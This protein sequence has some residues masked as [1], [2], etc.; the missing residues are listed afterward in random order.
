[1][2][3]CEEVDQYMRP[4]IFA[5]YLPQ[6]HETEENNAWWGK[7]Y[8]DWTAVKRSSPLFKGHYQPR[9]PLNRNYYDLTNVETIR[10][11]AAMAKKYG[12]DGLCIYHYWSKGKLIMERPA[13]ILLQASDI[14]ISFFLSWAN[15]DFKRTWFDG[16][17]ACL[18]KQEYGD[19]L[20]AR[21]HYEY[22]SNFFRDD[23]YKK[24]NN[25]PVLMIHN[26]YDI[27]D[28]DQKMSFWTKLAQAE[29]YAGLYIIATKTFTMM[30]SKE[31]QKFKYVDAV[32]IFEPMNV[33]TNGANEELYYIYI[34]RAR[35]WLL[36]QL[37]RYLKIQKPEIF[38]YRAANERMLKRNK[39]G[40]QYYCIFP[41][42]DN[43]PRYGGKGIVFRGS[44]P[45]LFEYYAKRF[46]RR[47]A[48]EGCEFLLVNAWNEWGESAYLEPDEKYGY[49][50]L[51][52]LKRAVDSIR[53]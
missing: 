23:R 34:R 4:E 53:Q 32:F 24:I 45:E 43:T 38:D 29:G 33:R 8:T 1:M 44:T 46:Y 36:R 13:E 52:A 3:I 50:Y 5:L 16:D 39:C 37:S 11:Q 6:F 35:T 28:F 20:E 47:S 12:V 48:D 19:E 14:D 2:A 42:W 26:I 40:K 7:G 15:H 10:E 51:E 17:G 18:R 25:R 31:M 21:A 22:L 9:I 27:P 41:G 49:A 30:R